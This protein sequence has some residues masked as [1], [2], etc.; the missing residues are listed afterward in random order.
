MFGLNHERRILVATNGTQLSGEDRIFPLTQAADKPHLAEI[1][2][3]PARGHSYMLHF[4]L[5]PD[6]EAVKDEHAIVLTLPNA[7][8]WTFKQDGGLAC[9]LGSVY[10]DRTHIAP[11]ATK[12]IVVMART[13]D[14]VG[15]IRW[16]FT[17]T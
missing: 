7:E 17:K 15:A 10:L 4:H 16:S 5:H 11:R 12:Q 13:L 1:I 14:Y 9:L 3:G 6:V 8:V 2:S